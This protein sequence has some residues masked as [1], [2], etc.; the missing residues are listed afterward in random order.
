M[1]KREIRILALANMRLFPGATVYDVG[2]GSGS[3]AI[4]CKR[5][6]GDGDVFA[7]EQH[8]QAI[9]TIDANCKKFGVALHVLEGQ[10]PEALLGLPMADRIFIGGSGGKLAEIIDACDQQLRPGGRIVLTSV[11]MTTGSDAYRIFRELSYEVEVIQVN[12]A[13]LT[14]VGNADLWKARNPVTLITAVKG[15]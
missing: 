14:T 15:E 2:A 1:T 6:V 7:V 4:E 12:V 3:V 11:T 8:G 13:Q 9:K 5:L 10:A